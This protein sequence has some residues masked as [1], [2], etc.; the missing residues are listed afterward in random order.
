LGA[1]ISEVLVE[2]NGDGTYRRYPLQWFER[3]RLEYHPEHAS[4]P[5]AIELGLLGIQAL[6]GPRVASAP[7][8]I[9]GPVCIECRA[10]P[11]SPPLGRDEQRNCFRVGR[12][13][14]VACCVGRAI[15]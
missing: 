4:T 14:A 5:Y 10:Y 2:G 3:G 6:Q 13:P 11:G 7:D 8:A 15:L 9:R 12:Q 1:P